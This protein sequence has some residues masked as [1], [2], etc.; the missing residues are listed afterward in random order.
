MAKDIKEM[1]KETKDAFNKQTLNTKDLGRANANLEAFYTMKDVFEKQI[2]DDQLFEEIKVDEAINDCKETAIQRVD[3]TVS[4][5]QNT[6]INQDDIDI[7]MKQCANNLINLEYLN[8]HINYKTYIN[9]NQSADNVQNDENELNQHIQSAIKQ[10]MNFLTKDKNT[11]TKINR[12]YNHLLDVD[13]NYG[14]GFTK[15]HPAFKA[16]LAK[17]MN[18]KFRELDIN[19]LISKLKTK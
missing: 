3:K 4:Q 1:Q 18:Q 9:E 13:S 6:Q 5:I 17:A 8:K 19:A 11:K 10:S 12:L 2:D 14:T 16:S 15:Q 7:Y